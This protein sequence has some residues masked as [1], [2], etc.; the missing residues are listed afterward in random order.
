MR[1]AMIAFLVA[2][3]SASMVLASHGNGYY[4][5]EHW[6]YKTTNYVGELCE[7]YTDWYIYDVYE[8]FY[9]VYQHQMW[10]GDHQWTGW[11]YKQ[12]ET[13]Q[14]EFVYTGQKCLIVT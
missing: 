2:L 10:E 14:Y 9:D 7:D 12:G 8:T 3:L 1:K 4:Y 5:E 11:E 6:H 13:S